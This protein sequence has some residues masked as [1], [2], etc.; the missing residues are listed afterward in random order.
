M[1]AACDPSLEQNAVLGLEIAIDHACKG[2]GG[3]LQ[4]DI[5]DKTQASVIDADQWHLHAR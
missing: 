3:V 4:R 1:L 5:C 2:V